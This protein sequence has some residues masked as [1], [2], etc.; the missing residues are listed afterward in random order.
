MAERQQVQETNRM[1]QSLVAQIFSDFGFERTNIGDTL[2]WV[3]TTPLGSAVV[4]EVKTISKASEAE[5]RP[6]ETTL[7]N[8]AKSLPKAPLDRWSRCPRKRLDRERTAPTWFAPAHRSGARTPGSRRRRQ[9]PQSPRTARI[10]R[11]SQ[12]TPRSSDT[13]TAPRRPAYVAS[14]QLASKAI[15][16]L[17]HLPIAPALVPVSPRMHVSALV[18]PGCKVVQIVQQTCPHTLFS[19]TIL[20]P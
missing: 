5:S 14:L 8:A 11:T 15:R 7:P 20:K 16:S 2:A 18:A 12:P 3:I 9:E 19:S 17:G 6:A 4:P 13:T 10:Q 1:H